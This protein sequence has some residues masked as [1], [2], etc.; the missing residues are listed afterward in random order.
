MVRYQLLIQARWPFCGRPGTYDGNRKGSDVYSV[1][2]VKGRFEYCNDLH[3][4]DAVY[5]HQCNINFRTDRDIPETFQLENHQS[6]ERKRGRPTD[7][8]KE[9]DF[10]KGVRYLEE[11]DDEQITVGELV[12]KMEE[13]CG[14]DSYTPKYMKKRVIKH[15]G[16][17]VIVI[18]INGKPNVVTFCSN[19]AS[20]LHKFYE[21]PK[22][23]DDNVEKLRIIETVANLIKNDIKLAET[24]KIN[25]PS[26]DDTSSIEQNLDFIPI[27]LRV[28]LR[29]LFPAKTAT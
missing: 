4:S 11:N 28:F 2:Q 13:Y 17:D 10:L 1:R 29:K 24:S 25:Y 21:R 16:D 5:H 20:S 23:Q 8:E 3:A 22:Q 15:L 18:E 12:S 27:T 6:A 26:A 19:A 7:S 14:E 9:E